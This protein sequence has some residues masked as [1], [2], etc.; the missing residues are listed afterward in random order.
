MFSGGLD[1][2]LVAGLM[3]RQDIEVVGL[4]CS[5]VFHEKG[6]G[7]DHM[8]Q[9]R[10]V[11]MDMGAGAFVCK[12]INETMIAFTKDPVY[13]HGKHMNACLDCRLAIIAVAR[14]AMLEHG[15]DFIV[16]GEVLGQRPMSQRRDAFDRLNPAITSMGLDGL[17]LRPLSA[18]LFT[19]TVPEMR[20]WVDRHKLYAF[21]G[22]TRRPQ[23]ALAAKLGITNY[24]SPAGGCLLTDK[25]FSSRLRDLMQF[26]SSLSVEDIRLLR[27]GRHYRFNSNTKVIV[28]RNE[29]EEAGLKEFVHSGDVLY[30]ARDCPGALVLV[31]GIH[32]AQT[33]RFAAALAAYYS[34]HR[35]ERN[36]H[37]LRRLANEQGELCQTAPIPL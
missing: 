12:N 23:I 27:V 31:R 15:A 3:A 30:S 22:R 37:V 7:H 24:P 5:S 21:S 8:E 32:T 13:G 16:S 17:L 2:M 11:C 25:G 36:I 28:T 6:D 1:S 10:K 34:K 4:H 29:S 20:G 26:S 18:K 19:A 9:M 14:K 33:D 35:N